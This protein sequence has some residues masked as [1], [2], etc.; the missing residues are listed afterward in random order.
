MMQLKEVYIIMNPFVTALIRLAIPLVGIFNMW[1]ISKG[2]N[3]LPFSE[4]EVGQAL[5][6]IATVLTTVWAWWK[7]APITKEAQTA[8]LYLDDLKNKKVK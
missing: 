4:E 1:L 6:A 7:N 5:V 3:P 2:M 8:Q